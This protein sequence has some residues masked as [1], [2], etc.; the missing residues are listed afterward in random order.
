MPANFVRKQTLANAERYI[1]EDLK[2]LENKISGANE[3]LAVLERQLFDDLLHKISAELPRIQKTASGVARLDVLTALAEVAVKK[4]LYKS[5]L[6]MKATRLIIEEGRHPVIEQMLK[7]ALFVPNDTVL[8]CG[9]NRM[10]I[11]T[12]PNMAGKSYMRQT[13]LIAL[14]AQIGS[15]VPARR[16]AW[17]LWMLFSPAWA[18]QTIWLRGN[19]PLWW[20]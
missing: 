15:F 8:D 2:V 4:R 14:M 17:A 18:L 16:A 19:P 9:D 1:T 12:G 6:W 11:I 13:A 7:G 5:R 20:R 3:R 10:L